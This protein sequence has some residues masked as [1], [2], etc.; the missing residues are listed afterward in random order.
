MIFRLLA[1]DDLLPYPSTM[2][3]A[4]VSFWTY[5]LASILVTGAVLYHAITTRREFYPVVI[6]LVTSK[7][8][9]SVRWQCP[10]PRTTLRC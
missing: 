8:S 2:F 1:G 5:S 6:Y 3:Q 10:T 9:I 4:A 7:V